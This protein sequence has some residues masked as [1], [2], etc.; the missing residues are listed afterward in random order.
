[1]DKYL[2]YNIYANH[3]IPN[4]DKMVL[5]RINKYI[6]DNIS[7]LSGGLLN[8]S[9]T[10]SANTRDYLSVPYQINSDAWTKISR[11]NQ[12]SLMKKLAT[13]L[14]L[15]LI[16]S[17]VDTRQAIFLN[18]LMILIYSSL[19]K[20]YFPNGYNNK[21]MKYTIDNADNRT[22]FKKNEGSLLVTVN[23]KIETFLNLFKRKLDAPISDKDLR[24][25]LQSLTTRI[26][27]AVK[28]ISN[29]YYKNFH[30]PEVKIMIEYTQHED[31]KNII[32][33]LGVMEAIREKAVN[34]LASANNNIL[35]MI[36]LGPTNVANI[37]YRV[38]FI[39][40]IPD[41]FGL[42]SQATSEILDSWIKRN[43]SK[44]TVS[45]F[46]T[47]FVKTM[48]KARNI[49]HIM[50]IIEGIGDKMFVTRTE[51]QKSKINRITLRNYLYN[52]LILNL[53]SA[54]SDIAALITR[55]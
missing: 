22:D 17:Y 45:G 43:N 9:P 54:S 53:Y 23:K 24:E 55:R 44:I 16:I 13:P 31:G 8:T 14:K 5:E 42:M 7:V 52:Y 46:R 4:R 20:K 30:D 49:A 12:F 28:A 29:K 26:N 50:A 6:S 21:I 32:S 27:E 47:T 10:F 41:N 34:N 19:M 33:P 51:D 39:E 3:K 36:G 11:S 35:Q 40:C 38:M 48:V 18:F 2:I 1:M 37:S 25:A 15:G